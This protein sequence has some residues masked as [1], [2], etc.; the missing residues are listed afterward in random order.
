MRRFPARGQSGRQWWWEPASHSLNAPMREG[1]T[2]S[3]LANREAYF[4]K[5][6][7]KKRE[8][9]EA[10]VQDVVVV[11]TSFVRMVCHISF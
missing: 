4:Q 11:V 3:N 5:R 7:A 8:K 10:A 2:N 1:L 6:S 9:L